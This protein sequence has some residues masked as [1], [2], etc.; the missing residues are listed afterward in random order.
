M[1]MA[2]EQRKLAAILFVDAVGSSR[3]MGRDESGTVARLLQHLNQRLAP[4]AVRR[5]GRVIR[6]KGDGG[7][8]E[9]TSAVDALAAAIEFQQAMVN[10]NVGQPEDKAILFRIGLHLGD[11]IVE[12]D[13]IYGDD[14]NVAARL[15]AEAPP[16][17]IA[18]SRAV[19]DAVQGRLKANLHTMGE[20]TLKNID[21]PVRA[22]RVEWGVEDWPAPSVASG[23]PASPMDL[24]PVLTLPDKPSIAV[25][26]FQN[27]SGDPEQ[28][29]FVDGLVDDIIIGLSRFKSL[30]VIAR[31]SSFTYK[32]KAVD[33]KQVGH[34]LG[35]RYVLEGS[36]RK[37]SNRVRITGQ[38]IDALSGNHIW[39][40]HYDSI[41]DDV[42]AIQ[43][44]ITRSIIG[45]IAPEIEASEVAKTRRPSNLTAY[46][47]A[48]RANAKASQGAFK[49][50]RVLL[51]DAIRDARAALA[52][53]GNSTIAL[54]AL[55]FAQWVHLTLLTATDYDAAWSESMDAATRAIEADRSDSR[56]YASK[57]TILIWATDR[58]RYDEALTNLRYAYQLNP[59]SVPTLT[60][61]AFGE[62]SADNS[63]TVFGYLQE[64]LRLSPREPYKHLVG[65]LLAMA[66]LCTGQY[67]AG[68]NC[69]RQALAEAPQHGVLHAYLAANLVGLGEI[70]AAREALT[71]ARRFGPGF[72]ERG[73][74]GKLKFRKPDQL[75][76]ATTFLR[77]AAGLEDP[78]AADTLR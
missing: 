20:L 77:I 27:M 65:I 15:E 1:P 6:M 33:V 3:L 30:F 57:G 43:E 47:L 11:V 5:G 53:D 63:E 73:L 10:A 14:V 4:A 66:C 36:V 24:A 40:D 18:I 70:A 51:D 12:G 37:A 9:F 46:E 45:A 68:T 38:L 34:E 52:I 23:T 32:A 7:L 39:A 48:V 78:S 74:E 60:S 19:R 13:D 17:G 67:D 16:G 42:F 28:E 31:N 54:N 8:V 69:A 64:A 71:D 59:Q 29:Y 61:L 2:R 35:V 50:D 44:T 49:N 72:V 25:L 55:S 62:I 76:R 58:D 75:H 22:F 21:R 26:P 41:L 56:G